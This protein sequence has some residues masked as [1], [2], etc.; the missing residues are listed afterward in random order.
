VQPE[1]FKAIVVGAGPGG[2]VALKELSEAGV[3]PI[4]CLDRGDGVGGLF[5][6]GYDGLF[7][8][9]SAAFSMFSDFPPPDGRHSAF[10]TKAEVQDY[11]TG[12]ANRFGLPALIRFGVTVGAAE[13]RPEGGWRLDCGD[14]V[15]TCDH[16]VVA[17]GN[18][19]YPQVPDWAAAADKVEVRHSGEYRDAAPFRGRSVVVVGGGESASDMTLEIAQV[20]ARTWVSLRRGPGWVVPR[21]RGELAA[22]ISTHRG[23]WSLPY[24]CGA[25]VSAGL[26][27]ADA[28]RGRQS[29]VLAEVAKLNAKVASPFG[30][31]GIFGTKSL[32]L[33]TAIAEHGTQVVGDVTEVVDGGRTL[34][35]S[36][37]HR[38]EGVDAILLA[39]GFR[40]NAPFLPEPMRAI[41]P[42][43]M[44]KNMFRP[45]LGASLVMIG[46]ARPTFGSQFPVMELQARLAARVINGAQVLPTAA[47]MAEI[48]AKDS[49]DLTQQFGPTGDRVR[50]LVDYPLY[51]DAMARLIGCRPRLWQMALTDPRLWLHVVYGPMQAT[52]YRLHGPGAKPVEAR[53]ILMEMPVSPFN[54]IVKAGLHET[55]RDILRLGP[56][57]RR[58]GQRE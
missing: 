2:I 28:R 53:R 57:W 29:P 39:T 34:L 30:I 5:R 40:S 25:R 18:N 41:D 56:V 35:T 31:R 42:R 24:K 54:H 7:L 17:T 3:G 46:F 51:M 50:G 12:Y 6:G 44:Y 1:H 13:Q 26:I 20:A 14:K 37:G 8:T 38:I 16:L 55:L 4:V 32:G 11:W 15:L 27:A 33:P 43:R 22:D 48:A 21:M 10:W 47:R 45:E 36:D 19:V 52:Q 49:A 9:S 23:F 58:L